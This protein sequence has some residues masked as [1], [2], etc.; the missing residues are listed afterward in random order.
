MRGFGFQTTSNTSAE[1]RRR[2]AWASAPA[3]HAAQRPTPQFESVDPPKL[4]AEGV[5]QSLRGGRLG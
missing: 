3:E 1:R 2:P 4:G 5:G